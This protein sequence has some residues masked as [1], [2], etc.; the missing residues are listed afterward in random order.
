[1]ELKETSQWEAG[2]MTFDESVAFF[3]KIIDDGEVCSLAVMYG[4]TAKRL[5]EAGFCRAKAQV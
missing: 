1:M 4:K 3:Q 2:Q 5:I